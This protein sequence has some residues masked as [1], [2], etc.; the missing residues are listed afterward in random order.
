MRS[1]QPNPREPLTA[2]IASPKRARA[3]ITGAMVPPIVK[4]QGGGLA[5]RENGEPKA[6]T[7]VSRVSFQVCGQSKKYSGGLSQVSLSLLTRLIITN[8]FTGKTSNESRAGARDHSRAVG[9]QRSIRRSGEHLCWA[10]RVH[11]YLSGRSLRGA[12]SKKLRRSFR[13]K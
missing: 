11:P 6:G 4:P 3:I 12:A 7:A 13:Q 2:A 8:L 1:R 5:V 10:L 9:K